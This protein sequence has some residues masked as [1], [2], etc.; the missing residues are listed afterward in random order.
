MDNVACAGTEAALTS[1]DHNGWGAHNCGHGEDA[2]VRCAAAT[3]VNAL[4][5]AVRLADGSDASE[6]R[7]E[8][9]HDGQWGTVC[10]DSWG[11]EDATVVCRQL[12]FGGAAEAVQTWGGGSG[13]I[14]CVVR[15]C[16]L[17]WL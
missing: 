14:W 13:Q 8:I 15:W 6:G 16:V 2:G 3:T 10:D 11:S 5:G 7:V 1:C 4:E 17:W 9:F 12:G